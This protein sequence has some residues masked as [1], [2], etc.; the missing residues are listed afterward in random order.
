[1]KLAEA[2]AERADAQRRLA[3]LKQ[4]VVLSARVQ[5]GEEPPEDPRELLSEADRIVE[6]LEDLIKRINRTNASSEFEAGASVTEA[7]AR[8]DV[9]SI[10]RDLYAEAAQAASVRQDRYSRSEVKFVTTLNISALR[11]RADELSKEYRELDA[12]LQAK[13]WEIELSE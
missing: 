5:E 2:L 11:R 7:L 10:Q 9:L 1:M 6:Q 4:R 8:W 3:Q 12:R 13:N